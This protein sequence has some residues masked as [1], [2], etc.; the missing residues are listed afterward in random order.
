MTADDADGAWRTHQQQQ[1]L[2]NRPFRWILTIF[3]MIRKNVSRV[4][5]SISQQQQ[6]QFS[7]RSRGASLLLFVLVFTSL[8][9]EWMNA[10]A[11]SVVVPTTTRRRRTTLV[12]PHTHQHNDDDDY[13]SRP[14]THNDAITVAATAVVLNQVIKVIQTIWEEEEVESVLCY[15]KWRHWIQQQQQKKWHVTTF[16]CVYLKLSWWVMR[17]VCVHRLRKRRLKLLHRP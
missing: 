2:L 16:V 7:F 1:I 4:L 13:N 15:G 10:A 17:S 8:N 14:A 12:S 9:A 6:Q 3:S 11:A 5:P